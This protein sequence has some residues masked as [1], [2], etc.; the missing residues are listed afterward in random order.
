VEHP[1]TEL[2]TGID[3]VQQ[4]V[5]I[6]A[7]EKLP[8]GQDDI[9]MTGHAVEARVYAEDPAHGF[10]PTGGE[11]LALAEPHGHGVRVDSG[12]AGGTVVGSDY[13]P[14]LA[15]VIAHGDDRPSA[16]RTLDR[17][18]AD[19]AV[20]GVTTN[21]EFLRFLL[22]DPDVVAGRLDTGLLDRRTTDFAAAEPSDDE[23]IA[24]AAYKWLR[25]WPEPAGNLWEVP[26]GWRMGQHA[27]TTV[28]L[29]AGERTD[30]VYLTG[31]P[32]AATAVI[33]DG[34]SHRL[35]AT[36]DGD[37]LVV[38][39]DG[40]RTD[41]LVAAADGQLWL[42]RAGHTAVL[43]EVREAPVR[44]EDEHSG[45]AELVSPMP[46]AVVA[47]GVEDGATVEA[48]AVVV[49]VEAMKME[50]ALTAPV[51]GVVELLVAVG[52]QVKVGQPLARITAAGAGKDTEAGDAAKE[53]EATEKVEQS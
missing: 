38:T 20:L 8:I 47:V 40:L 39:L 4:Q 36:L 53:T 27:A 48:G 2:V 30:H 10:L 15:K 3:L 26:S 9:T 34:Q 1:V 21:V 50:H 12:L 28:R 49:A 17:A 42:A 46:G 16:L 6:A 29:H 13:D 11:V 45:D 37:R 7:G 43:D 24:A 5:R 31:A 19:T 51:D 52:D 25:S 22:S 41:Y 23:L 35:T 14:M 44:P 33:E 18:L 32:L